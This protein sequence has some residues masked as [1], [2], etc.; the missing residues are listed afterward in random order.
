[1][2]FCPLLV[3]TISWTFFF[4][5]I[6]MKATYITFHLQ[7]ERR[8]MCLL[9]KINA[10]L[11]KLLPYLTPIAVVIGVLL[12]HWGEQL[13][14]LVPW[15]FAYMTFS[16]SLSMR[17]NQLSFMIK[18]PIFIVLSLLCLHVIMPAIAYL[19]ANFLFDDEL[20]IIGYVLFVAIPT[21]VSSM[22]WV[23]L[24]KGNLPL[25][26]AIILVDTL[27]SPL[28]MPLVVHGII[29]ER[30]ALDTASLVTNLII[31][32]VLPSVIAI[33]I[34]EWSKGHAN[35]TL[36]YYFNPLSKVI[37]LLVI[38]INSSAVA[39][40][41][42]VF[43]FELVWSILF[44]FALAC[45]GYLVS[46]ILARLI[47]KDPSIVIS[48][49]YSNSMR[50]IA[51]GIVIAT[52]HFPAKIAMPIIFG[53]LFQQLTASFVSRGLTRFYERKKAIAI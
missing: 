37:I 3:K 6:K 52:T 33:L 13:T 43:S 7:E 46:F 14:W 2:L 10:K 51:L 29:G 19:L 28:I 17:F 12:H 44:V 24:C 11:Q 8:R 31:M 38:M 16:S 27:L 32:I 21:G 39:P 22:L 49:V 36:G 47:W 9:L 5:S 30:I 23:Q 25:T 35:Q 48:F 15:L 1:M 53:M 4:S 45:I 34:N 50:N 41:M 42:K 20:L 18:N 26:L 40:Y